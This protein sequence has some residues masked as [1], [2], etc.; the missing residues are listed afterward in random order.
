MTAPAIFLDRDGTISEMVYYPEHALVD[1]PCSPSQLMLAEGAGPALRTFRR[2]GYKLVLISNQPGIAK[3][4]FTPEIHQQMVQR[5]DHLLG[6]E[7]VALTAQ[8]Y[9]L[10]HPQAKLAPYRL[11]CG[12]RKPEPG[13]LVQAAREHDLSLSDSITV[14]D[15]LTDV[16][17]GQRAG[18]RTILLTTVNSLITRLM[19]EREA[20]PSFLARNL[21][22]AAEQVRLIRRQVRILCKLSSWPAASVPACIR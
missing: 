14:G 12:C 20:E 7:G 2:L 16:L 1:S 13:L 15:S 3:E 10:H 22:E 8:Y 21:A 11:D 5:L 6:R 18:T 19:A 4:H 17:A 9:C